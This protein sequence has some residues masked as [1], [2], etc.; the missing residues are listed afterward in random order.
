MVHLVVWR[1]CIAGHSSNP[2]VGDPGAI[3]AEEY[4]DAGGA[5]GMVHVGERVDA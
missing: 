3:D 4:A 1:P 2:A 5:G